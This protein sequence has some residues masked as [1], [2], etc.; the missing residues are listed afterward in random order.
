MG[1]KN[2]LWVDEQTAGIQGLIEVLSLFEFDVTTIADASSAIEEIVAN[3]ATYCVI[4]ID[5]MLPCGCRTDL[6]PS[7]STNDGLSTGAV[8]AEYLINGHGGGCPAVPD[9]KRKLIFLSGASISRINSIT[10]AC[11]KKHG[12]PYRRKGT[13]NDPVEFA[14]FVA[15]FCS[16]HGLAID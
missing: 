3:H 1:K 7:V 13:S 9:I 11:S 10:E 16:S 6:F 5:V 8:L 12:I 15:R 4:I 2:V 14:D